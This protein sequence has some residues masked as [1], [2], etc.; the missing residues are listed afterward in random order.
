MKTRV[1]NYI[2]EVSR[3]ESLMALKVK[4]ICVGTHCGFGNVIEF[5]V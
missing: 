4:I 2:T 1:H 5:R 3:F